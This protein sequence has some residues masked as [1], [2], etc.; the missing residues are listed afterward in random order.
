MFPMQRHYW[1]KRL[2]CYSYSWTP[3]ISSNSLSSPSDFHS[4]F[5]DHQTLYRFLEACKLSLNS[6]TAAETHARIIK[7]GHGNYP[8]LVACLISTYARC[9]RIHLAR[10]I[11]DQVF[12]W[13][14]DLV[15]VNIIIE[16][17]MKNGES[18]F[19]KKVFYK[20]PTRDIVT[21]NSIIG[22]LVKNV[23]FQEAL[24]FFREMLSSNVQPDAST[25]ASIMS[26]C[27]RF[28][29]LKNAQWVHAL[30]IENKIELNSILSAALVDMYAKCGRIQTA[31][32]VFD[33]V[34][35]N[36]VSVWNA[37]INGLASHGLGSDALALFSKM[38]LENVL[39]DSITFIGIL[40]ACSHCGLVEQGCK[41]FDLMRNCYSIEPQLQH[42]GAMVDLLGRAGR[43]EEAYAIIDSMPME[44]DIVIW[45]ALLSACK[46][47]TKP[48]LGEIAI[49]NISRLRSGDYVLLSNIYCSLK[50]WDTAER[51]REMMKKTGV[52]KNRGKS[53]VELVGVIHQFKA[54]DRSHPETEAIYRVLKEL[55]KRVK[56]EGF[57]YVT[58][59]VLMD[60]SEEE[61][62]E[63]LNFHSEKLALAYGILKTSPGTEIRIF[64]NLRICH[65]CHCW[66]K[67]VSIVLNRVI[68]VRDRTRF[69]RFEGGL[70]SCV[71]YW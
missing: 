51:V 46:T 21:W 1:A 65:D 26:G 6:R 23:R 40:T 20:M 66:I 58:E 41:Y 56:L 50:R 35:R 52:R 31:K 7:F 34:R 22:G 8:S 49:A 9:D 2:T 27:A 70:C 69:H 55:I 19:A 54:G 67:V 62:E 4:A 30:V 33:S 36:D 63:N 16:S 59:L 45:R 71:D 42:Y 32:E 29:S 44:P 47:Y 13:D 53:W 25:F 24:R 11:L 60:V 39:P 68:I 18:D 5:E 12:C 37:I 57:T 43:L 28:G 38:E 61:K 17:L 10:K 48:A 3:I 15:S 64:K 14:F